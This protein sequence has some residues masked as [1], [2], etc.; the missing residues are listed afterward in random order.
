MGRLGRSEQKK[1]RGTLIRIYYMNKKNYFQFENGETLTVRQVQNVGQPTPKI[2][3]TWAASKKL[4]LL[5][6]R[7]KL[8]WEKNMQIEKGKNTRR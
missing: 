5:S 3:N 8:S 7:K 1:R 2:K 6:D 4:I